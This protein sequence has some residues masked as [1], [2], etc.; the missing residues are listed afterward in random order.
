MPITWCLSDRSTS[1]CFT[2]PLLHFPVC[3]L[4]RISLEMDN[5]TIPKFPQKSSWIWHISLLTWLRGCFSLQICFLYLRTPGGCTCHTEGD[6]HGISPHTKVLLLRSE[7]TARYFLDAGSAENNTMVFKTALVQC[8]ELCLCSCTTLLSP[9]F[10]LHLKPF[11][12]VTS[13]KQRD[14][15]MLTLRQNSSFI[16]DSKGVI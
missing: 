1:S 15:L 3:S 7:P 13:L 9:P 12:T 10:P 8:C 16:V 11:I 5:S 4:C 6:V 2:T 14:D